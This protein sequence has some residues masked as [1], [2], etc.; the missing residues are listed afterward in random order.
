MCNVSKETTLTTET[1]TKKKK[2]TTTKKTNEEKKT[3]TAV[4]AFQLFGGCI[5]LLGT[6]KKDE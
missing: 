6:R 1:K 4:S 2:N 3:K 5:S